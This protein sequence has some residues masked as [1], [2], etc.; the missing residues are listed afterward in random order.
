MHQF[1]YLLVLWEALWREVCYAVIGTA[2]TQTV[3][4]ISMTAKELAEE[5]GCGEDVMGLWCRPMARWTKDN[6]AFHIMRE[7]IRRHLDVDIHL[8]DVFR[9]SPE[10]MASSATGFR[11][12]G[13]DRRKLTKEL[14]QADPKP[15]D[16][17]ERS[18]I[19]EK[20]QSAIQPGTWSQ[21]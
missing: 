20:I 18:A 19:W 11:L 9:T 2:V 6:R 3:E 1:S 16:D 4:E 10:R 13:R 8:P 17:K 14:R 7:Q 12:S 21:Q 15:L 5:K